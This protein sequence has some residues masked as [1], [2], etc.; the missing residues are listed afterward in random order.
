M[1]F[2]TIFTRRE[3]LG[4]SIGGVGRFNKTESMFIYRERET[5]ALS[6]VLS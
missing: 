1:Q 2:I 3:Y 6:Q 5:D 4:T